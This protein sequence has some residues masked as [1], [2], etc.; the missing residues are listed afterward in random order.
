MPY[1]DNVKIGDGF[2]IKNNIPKS[3]P[4]SSTS[5]AYFF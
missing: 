5:I 3:S 1:N 4:F 2:D